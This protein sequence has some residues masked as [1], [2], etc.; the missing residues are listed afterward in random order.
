[1][2]QTHMEI[3]EQTDDLQVMNLS[4]YILS[5][6]K[7]NLLRKGIIFVPMNRYNCFEWVKDFN[8]FIR[9]VRWARHFEI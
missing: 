4:D 2:K 8:L 7:N 6:D 9:K 1:M 3:P 5:E